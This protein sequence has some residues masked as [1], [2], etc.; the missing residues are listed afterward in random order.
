MSAFFRTV[1]VAI[2]VVTNSHALFPAHWVNFCDACVSAPND[3]RLPGAG[4]TDQ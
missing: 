3:Q 1:V 2:S 4:Q